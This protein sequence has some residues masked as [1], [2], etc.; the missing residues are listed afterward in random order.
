MKYALL[1]ALAA[2]ACNTQNTP[3]TPPEASPTADAATPSSVDGGPCGAAVAHLLDM[4]CPF[5]EGNAWCVPSAVVCVT[6]AATCADSRGC[7][8]ASP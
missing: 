1:V 6:A 5:P 7:P 2:V 8:G 4:G 3:T